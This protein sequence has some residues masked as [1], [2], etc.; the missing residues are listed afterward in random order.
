MQGTIKNTIYNFKKALS[1]LSYFFSSSTNSHLSRRD[2]SNPYLRD[3]NDRNIL[4][5]ALSIENG[6][7]RSLEYGCWPEFPYPIN[8]ILS[9]RSRTIVLQRV[10]RIKRLVHKADR[11]PGFSFDW[12]RYAS[13]W[14]STSVED[15][16]NFM[17]PLNESREIV[18]RR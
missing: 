2:E 13:I 6:M 11:R 8:G 16:V 10:G 15:F 14:L 3:G 1:R 17:L 4:G 5:N 18:N 12:K 7:P 9:F